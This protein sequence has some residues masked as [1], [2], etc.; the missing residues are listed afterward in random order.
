MKFLL[1]LHSQTELSKNLQSLSEKAR[2]TTEFVQRLKIMND[3]VVVSEIYLT[4][5]EWHLKTFPPYF[6]VSSSPG[7][8]QRVRKCR[9]L[10]VRLT[11]T[12]DSGASRAAF[13]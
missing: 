8:L 5:L 3:K 1:S 11:H 10:A 7:V 6:I 4:V 13:R 12:D 2:S 9:Q